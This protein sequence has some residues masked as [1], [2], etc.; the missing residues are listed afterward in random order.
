MREVC[1]FR[2]VHRRCGGITPAYAGSITGRKNN[3]S[4]RQDHPRVCGKY[5]FQ[6]QLTA[7][8]SGS[9]PRMREVSKNSPLLV[10][11]LRITP[12]YAGSILLTSR[13]NSSLWDHPRVCG[14]YFHGRGGTT[15]G[16]GS[17]PRM[18]EVYFHHIEGYQNNRITPAY[19]G[20]IK[21]FI[22]NEF[23]DKDHPRVCGKYF[24]FRH[25][26]LR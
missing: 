25:I 16:Q 20:S 17:P 10:P 24:Q 19:A 21:E 18:R 5:S 23:E 9:P 13:S 1:T 12:A 22:F 2:D 26:F 8:I 14:K 6:F 11:R 15:I 3:R 4:Y 7:T